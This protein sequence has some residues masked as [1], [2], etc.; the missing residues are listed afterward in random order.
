MARTTIVGAMVAL[1]Y[2][3][4]PNSPSRKNMKF[5]LVVVSILALL[6]GYSVPILLNSEKYGMVIRFA[7]EAFFNY[8]EYGSL[9]TESSNDLQTMYRF[10]EQLKTYFIGDGWLNH[11]EIE[12]YYYMQTDVGYLRLIYFGGIG[13]CLLWFIFHYLMLNRIVVNLNVKE[14]KW[15]VLTL[16]VFL[17]IVNVKGLADFY[18]LVFLLL[19]FSSEFKALQTKKLN[20]KN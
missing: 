5:A 14:V 7:F 16:F 9:E 15:F 8:T 18:P 13:Y 6:I 20:E 4:I 12:G 2:L 17:V 1:G 3:M 10:P 11:P 19:I